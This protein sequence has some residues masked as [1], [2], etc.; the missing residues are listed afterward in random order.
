MVEELKPFPICLC[1]WKMDL[2]PVEDMWHGI[3]DWV[4]APCLACMIHPQFTC[5]D[6]QTQEPDRFGGGS[7]CPVCCTPL[8]KA[9]LEESEVFGHDTCCR[10]CARGFCTEC[11][12]LEVKASDRE[13]G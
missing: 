8:C 5:G 2:V 1:G 6:C 11:E 3:V 10:T 13:E 9:C 4:P 7:W 12:Q